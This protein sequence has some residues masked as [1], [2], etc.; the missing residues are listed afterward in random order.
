MPGRQVIIIGAAGRDL[1]NF[2]T[3]YR[4]NTRYRDDQM[5]EVVAFTAG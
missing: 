3:G 4:F 2:N 1:R 5:V